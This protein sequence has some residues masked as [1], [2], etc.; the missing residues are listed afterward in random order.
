LGALVAFFLAKLLGESFVR[1][2]FGERLYTKGEAL[3]IGTAFC[4][5][6]GGALQV[7]LLACG[8]L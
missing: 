5:A 6:F 2:I 7:S 8:H 4:G 1:K 3:F